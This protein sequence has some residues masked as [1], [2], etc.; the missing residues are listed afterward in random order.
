MKQLLSLVLPFALLFAFAY[1]LI[2]RPQSKRMKQQQ[3]LLSSLGEGD[4]VLLHSG[5]FGTIS[6]VGE[7]QAI[8]ELAPGVEITVLKG[9]ISRA[10]SDT[11]EEFEFDD[12]A[13]DVADED[14]RASEPLDDDLSEDSK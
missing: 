4:R 10:V 2:L 11:E 7:N 6:H 9:A 1:F 5:L 14:A 13:E 3:E 8:V 12:A